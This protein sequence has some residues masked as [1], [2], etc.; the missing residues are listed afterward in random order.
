MNELGVSY[1]FVEILKKLYQETKATVWC[2]DDGGL[3]ETFITG[4]GLKQG[5]V[6]SPLLFALFLNDLSQ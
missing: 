5:C 1:K 4:N 2:G 6:M 3:T